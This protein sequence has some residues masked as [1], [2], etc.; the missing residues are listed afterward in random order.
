MTAVEVGKG[1]GSADSDGDSGSG[2]EVGQ[3]VR[4][5]AL[6]L[7]GSVTAAVVSFGTVGI[8]TNAYGQRGAGVFFAATALFTLAA[9]ASRLGAESGLTYF[10]SRLRADDRHRSIPAAVRAGLMATGAVAGLLGLAGL[11]GAPLLSELVTSESDLA[12]SATIMIR[13]LAVAVPTFALSQAMFGASRGFGTMRPAVFGG[14]IVRP[15]TQ[16]GFVVVAMLMSDELWPLAVAWALS[17]VATMATVG[18]WLTRRLTRVR[19]RNR[20]AEREAGPTDRNTGEFSIRE[21]WRFSAPRALSDLLSSMLER[22]DVLLVAI[23][24]GEAGAGLYGASN[25]LILAGQMLMM[26]TAQS[27]APMLAADFLKG[28]LGQAQT[29]LRIISGWNVT[30]LWPVFLCLTFGAETTLSL[31]G[32][33]FTEAAPL[34]IVLSLAFLI[35]T[36]LGIGDTLL[37]MT[38]DST[39]SLVNHAIAVGVM[40]TTALVLLPTYGTIGA[41]WAWAGSRVVLRLLAVLRVRHTKGIHAIGLP[42]VVAGLAAVAAYVPIG[43][44]IHDRLG[45]WA[46]IV[47][48]VLAGGALHLLVL[49]RVHRVLELGQLTQVVTRRTQQVAPSQS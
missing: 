7:I 3:A 16:L 49:T 4:G 23:I 5:T 44:V 12:E 18:T 21:Y 22:L 30:L 6:N 29:S 47:T 11:T 43:F 9:N 40:L 20:I 8:I 32:P 36:G 14:Q 25:R 10:V 38:G 33:E 39:A 17:S 46:A 2:R 37:M 27:M 45:G 35:I 24:V 15:L 28:R 19:D 41:A 26:A 42:V 1:H 31:F 13:I 48:H 34:V